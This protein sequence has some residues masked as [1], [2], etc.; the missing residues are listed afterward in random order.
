[1]TVLTTDRHNGPRGDSRPP[2]GGT[3]NDEVLLQS[4]AP[5]GLGHN[6][7]PQSEGT[8]RRI[9]N[10]LVALLR[11]GRSSPTA[12][13][14]AQR[15]SVSVRLIFYHF[16]DMESLYDMAMGIQLERHW[17]EMCPVSPDLGMP[18]RVERTVK[19]RAKLFEAIAP[20]RRAVGALTLASPAVGAR[21]AD[22]DA[23]LR[24][25][26][27]E[28]FSLELAHADRQ[29]GALLDALDAAASWEAWDRLRR[30]QGLSANGARNAM[31]RTLGSLLA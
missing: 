24:S 22:A 12:H 8:R 28:T 18:E 29:R 1:M 17:V 23:V 15:A 7:R 11:D 21:L 13:D 25:R 27:K 16:N 20:I 30:N 10:A 31:A 5:N 14:V 19:Q 3:P 4:E 2:R 9:A 26:L 6:H